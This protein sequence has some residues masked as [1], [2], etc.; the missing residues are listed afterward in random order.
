M[1]YD[2]E[3]DTLN[4]R[5][6]VDLPL[7]DSETCTAKLAVALSNR[8]A[9]F[10]L[11][12]VAGQFQLEAGELCAGGEAGRDACTGDGGSPLVC[13]AGSGRWT[14][15]GLVGWGLGCGEPLPA[16]Y[17]RL[18]HYRQFIETAGTIAPPVPAPAPI[19]AP[20]PAPAS[21]PVRTDVRLAAAAQQDRED[22][23]Q[24]V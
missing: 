7:V 4:A 21:T 6:Q 19:P 15:V 23:I 13:Q 11:G 5:V 20:A 3:D 14:V 9:E 24:F 16:V 1:S 22:A 8:S 10:G 17:T 18:S 2:D 12:A